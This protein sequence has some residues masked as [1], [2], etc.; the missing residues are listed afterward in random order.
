MEQAQ[1]LR[2]LLEIETAANWM[3]ILF[4]KDAREENS[5]SGTMD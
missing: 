5:T 4:G 3:S 2:K 1:G